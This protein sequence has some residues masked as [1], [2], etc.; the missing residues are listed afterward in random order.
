[1][2]NVY[3]NATGKYLP[4]GA[5]TN[6]TMEE[7][8]G[9]IYGHHS[10]LKS[11]VLRQNQIKSRYYAVDSNGKAFNTNAEMSAYAVKDAL[12]RSECQLND[13]DYLATSTTQG[14]L[15]V[16]GMA[17][18][19]QAHLG[20]RGVEI[21]NFQSVCGSSMMALKGAY[22][23]VAAGEAKVAAVSASEFSSRWFQPSFYE[24]AFSEAEYENPPMETE[25]LRFTLSDGAGAVILESQPNSGSRSLK[26]EWIK[27]RSFADRFP[28]CMYAGSVNNHE[29]HPW[30][31]YDSSPMEAVKSGAFI[32]RQDF[33]LLYKLFPVWIGYY[34]E[35]IERGLI[36]PKKIDYFLAHYSA[37]SLKKEM[38][39]LL[40]KTDAMIDESKWFTNLYEKGNTGSASILIMLEEL[41][42]ERKLESGSKILC[43]V[44]ESGQCLIA[45][46][47]LTVV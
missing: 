11:F 24:S 21:A 31:M 35:L 7:H 25:F 14:D 34:V 30:S 43:F 8:L 28:P 29:L 41:M 20:C 10:P 44:P 37:H 1:M 6:E 19:V 23:N 47:L 4:G 27:Q 38:I 33:D 22:L 3:I 9:F 17:S 42:N 45:F 13:I 26:I 36:V 18:Q 5:I 32:L 15:L 40:K 39:R 16:P 12:L 2:K 46:M